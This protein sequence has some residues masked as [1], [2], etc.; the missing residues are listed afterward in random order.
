MFTCFIFILLLALLN[1]FK[2]EKIELEDFELESNQLY[3]LSK[4]TYNNYSRDGPIKQGFDFLLKANIYIDDKLKK[5]K[6][7]LFYFFFILS[8]PSLSIYNP[9]RFCKFGLVGKEDKNSDKI[10]FIKKYEIFKNNNSTSNKNN[11]NNNEINYL[12][13]G[14]KEEFLF[15][16]I[17]VKQF[18]FYFCSLEKKD[19]EKM[20]KIDLKLQLNGEIYIFNTNSYESAENFY[21]NYLYILITCYYA[22]F[23]LYWIIKT[24]GNI[25]K[26][27]ITMG[28]FSITIPFIILESIM[29]L[30]FYIQM[31]DTGKYN[32]TFKIMEIIFRFIK[33]I[34][35]KV[36]YFF[37]ANGLQTL[38]KFPN[39][40][41]TQEFLVLLLIFLFAF[42]S[43]E[44]SLIKYESDFI[45]HPLLFLIITTIFIIAINFYIWFVYMYRRIKIYER[46]FKDK[47]FKKN[48]KI[49]N[50]YSFSLF[51]CF[52][53][54]IVYVIIFAITIILEN[55]FKKVYFKWVGD[56]AN[57]TMSIFFF[58]TLC[59]NLWEERELLFVNYGYENQMNDSN[60]NGNKSGEKN[61]EIFQKKEEKEQKVEIKNKNEN[62]N[63]QGEEN[64]AK[65]EEVKVKGNL[66]EE[67]IKN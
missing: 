27:N 46:N 9:E 22:A 32:Y 53:A 28:I 17:G 42:T 6:N 10:S 11:S 33:D 55:S 30:E 19:E 60:S 18:Y 23:S 65:N 57:R 41:D 3:P 43:Y 61:V 26:L 63:K 15:N 58:T 1:I 12:E 29:M 59:I 37:I 2:C 38:N 49:L 40:R 62:K 7:S 24:L 35:I 44:A 50:Q 47:N 8:N 31:R 45:L 54:F 67:E 51:A 36:V 14:I 52:I 4:F 34:G 21:R 13:N 20:K 48:A 39:K 5:S 25:S 16:E 56:L 66:V 64:L